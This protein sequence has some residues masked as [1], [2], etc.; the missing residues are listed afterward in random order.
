MTDYEAR[1]A[2]LETH[3]QHHEKQFVEMKTKVDEMHAL[4]MQAK[5]ARWAILG[6]AG[7]AGFLAG[8]LSAITAMFGFSLPK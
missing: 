6:I 7:I 2:V 1:I 4:L 3:R 5:G 8:K